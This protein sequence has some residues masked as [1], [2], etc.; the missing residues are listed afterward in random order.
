MTEPDSAD[1]IVQSLAQE[2]PSK[3]VEIL[4][5][6]I[7]AVPL[8]GEYVVEALLA[9]F[10]NDAETVIT[11]AVRESGIQRESVRRIIETAKNFGL[12][13]SSIY[14]YAIKGGATEEEITL[15]LSE[16]K[17]N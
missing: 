1:N 9:V 5:S 12:E 13:Q 10:P 7:S 15:A 3:I 17:I 4:S 8:V 16:N 2:H 6:A 11:T 14:E